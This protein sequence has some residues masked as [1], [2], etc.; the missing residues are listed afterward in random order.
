MIIRIDFEGKSRLFQNPSQTF[1]CYDLSSI[2]GTINEISDLVKQGFYAVGYLAYETAPAF[3]H[4]YVTK[5]YSLNTLPLL[6]FGIYHD[7]TN[8]NKLSD[9]CVFPT[10]SLDCNTSQTEYQQNILNIKHYIENG[11]TY[12]TNYTLQFKGEFNS[13][14]Y[15]YYQYLQQNNQANY[16]AY[17]QFDNS[18]ILS[19]SPELFFKIHND[20]IITKP[21][22]GTTAR[23][24]N[25]ADDQ[26]KKQTLFSEKNQAE[27]MMI[28]DLLRNDLSQISVTGTVT[29]SELFKAEKY[30]TVWQLTSTIQSRLKPNTTLFNILKALFPCGSITGAPKASTMQIIADIEKQPREVY[31]GTIGYIEPNFHK[32]IFNIPIRTLTINQHQAHYG[33]GGGITWDSTASGEYQEILQ[34]MALLTNPIA[35]PQYLFESMLYHDEQIFLLDEHLARL[36]QSA[37]YFNFQCNVDE[38]RANLNHIKNLIPHL[39]YKIRLCLMADGQF[40]TEAVPLNDMFD[41]TDISLSMQCINNQNPLVY[42]KTSNRSHL[43]NV[44]FGQEVI[45]FNQHRELTEFVNGNLVLLINGCWLTPKLTS[46]LLAGV[47]REYYLKQNQIKEAR[48]MIDDILKAEK[49][50]FINSVRKWITINPE[51]LK[52]IKNNIIKNQMVNLI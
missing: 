24:I 44:T 5:D 26:L 31:C 46:G 30:P 9:D 41:I 43:P 29:V 14:P 3:N 20:T 48:L 37:E 21:M 34:K 50:A 47:M 6:V 36:S 15:R 39:S 42:H 52:K 27:N 8:V 35:K 7:Y 18:H 22:K 10:I 49:M 51:V 2:E 19:I 32:A 4:Y 11:T 12:Q 45:L 33:V 25:L 1:I 28:V 23:G 40:T 17:I 16:C 13:D 38:I